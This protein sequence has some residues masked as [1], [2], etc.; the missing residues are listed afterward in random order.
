M[1]IK[2]FFQ[3][4]GDFFWVLLAFSG[5]MFLWLFLMIFISVFV[6]SVLK[7]PT[8]SLGEG[9]FLLYFFADIIISS[10]ST[11]KSYKKRESRRFDNA[12]T[13]KTAV[14][15]SH[16]TGL[17]NRN[18]P[19]YYIPYG[20]S[21][22]E[23]GQ[24]LLDRVNICCGQVNHAC[25][26][27]AFSD[28]YQ[29]LRAIVDEL[30]WVN[31]KKRVSMTPSPRD[32]WIQIQG[33]MAATIDNF[34]YRALRCVPY[35]GESRADALEELL[36][37]MEKD[38]IISSLLKPE[39]MQRIQQLREEITEIREEAAQKAEA[40]RRAELLN[41][42]GSKKELDLSDFDPFLVAD[43]LE[44]KLKFLLQRS[45]SAGLPASDSQ[46]VFTSFK[47][48]CESCRLPLAAS[49]RLE[50]L[51]AEYEPKFCEENPLSAIDAMDGKSFELWCSA[52]LCKLGFT[53]VSLTKDSNDD[54]VDLLAEKEGIRY[55]IQC[56]CYS[57]NLGK[58]PIQEVNAGKSMP[59]YRCQ[60]GAVLT[61]RY[62]SK[63]ARDLANANGVLLWDRDWIM[64]QLQRL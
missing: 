49:V 51:L 19:R 32:Q 39:N 12:A 59:Q 16:S 42:L 24:F 60:I 30:I 25:T 4:I 53:E 58:A 3:I 29:R 37:N 56:K 9:F 63:G 47:E 11:N 36:D 31:E 57:T 38:E 35:S 46:I 52:F 27:E 6:L 18:K 8:D 50:G 2:R 14:T 26:V 13:C 55:A 33:N 54:G 15:R 41:V 62:F 10:Y 1:S 45:L 48:N 7:M 23:H 43:T 61:N 44:Q 17:F 64:A 20:M 28:A 34:M 5:Y 21:A 22:G 40:N